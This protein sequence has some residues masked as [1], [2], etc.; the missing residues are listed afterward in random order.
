MTET[1]QEL[2]WRQTHWFRN[3]FEEECIEPPSWKLLRRGFLEEEALM[4][5]QKKKFDA[6]GSSLLCR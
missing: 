5:S 1:L 6:T 3:R 4:P 2:P